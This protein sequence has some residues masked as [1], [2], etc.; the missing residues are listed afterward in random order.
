MWLGKR[1]LAEQQWTRPG[2]WTRVHLSRKSQKLLE[3]QRVARYPFSHRIDVRKQ[4]LPIRAGLGGRCLLC[5]WLSSRP[6]TIT[7][8]WI[9]SSYYTGIC[10]HL[11]L[12][13]LVICLRLHRVCHHLTLSSLLFFAHN[14]ICVII[15]HFACYVF[16]HDCKQV[17]DHLTLCIYQQLTLCRLAI[18][19]V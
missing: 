14:N 8:A 2:Y 11:A 5:P 4:T 18:S 7:S 9:A 1:N 12:W 16:V 19:S 17:H 10:L 6:P 15:K 3:I 13:S